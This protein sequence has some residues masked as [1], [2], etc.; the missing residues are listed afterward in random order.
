VRDEEYEKRKD[1]R[2]IRMLRRCVKARQ[3]VEGEALQTCG[4]VE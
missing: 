2:V 3:S 1:I 4:E